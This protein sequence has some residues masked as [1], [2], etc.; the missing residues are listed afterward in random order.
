MRCAADADCP[1]HYGCEAAPPYAT[2][3]A[4]YEAA[5]LAYAAA[6][7][8]EALRFGGCPALFAPLNASRLCTPTA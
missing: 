7:P 3:R 8:L 2:R 6:Y 5:E 4:A 1:P